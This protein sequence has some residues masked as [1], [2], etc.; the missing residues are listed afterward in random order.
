MRVTWRKFCI[1]AAA[2]LVTQTI[3]GGVLYSA[4]VE[5][6]VQS[7]Y[8]FRNE[9][10]EQLV[11]Y[12]ASRVLLSCTFVYLFLKTTT[13]PNLRNG[14]HYGFVIW[15]LYSIPT[16]IGFWA[17]VKLPDVMAIAWIGVGLGEFIVAG[18][19]LGSLSSRLLHRS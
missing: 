5:P 17:F 11:P 12:F 2:V 8:F 10:D 19:V 9:G 15:L 13:I 7:P 4:L 16:V 6:F 18:A 3:I 14:A 1:A